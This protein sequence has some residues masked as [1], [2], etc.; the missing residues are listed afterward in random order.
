MGGLAASVYLYKDQPVSLFGAMSMSAKQFLLL[1]VGISLLMFLFSKNYTHFV[2]D[3]GGLAGGIA[4]IRYLRR[5]RG[6][7]K[8]KPR[9]GSAKGLRVIEGGG[10][11]DEPGKWLN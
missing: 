11:P 10:G 8:T 2:A 3:M 5:P 7:A 1:I 4:F 6:P 9:K